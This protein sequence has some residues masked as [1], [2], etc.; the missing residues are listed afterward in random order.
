MYII[1]TCGDYWTQ[2]LNSSQTLKPNVNI[3]KR[4]VEMQSLYFC[5]E[6]ISQPGLAPI[7]HCPTSSSSNH[8]LFRHCCFHAFSQT[9]P[10]WPGN[11]LSFSSL[12]SHKLSLALNLSR[13]VSISEV[14]DSDES[15]IKQKLLGIRGFHDERFSK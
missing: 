4:H 12:N 14:V 15:S 11:P 3:V 5:E 7:V 2:M 1:D 10:S 13:C 9:I 8:V 6:P